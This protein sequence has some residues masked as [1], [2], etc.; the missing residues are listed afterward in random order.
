MAAFRYPWE[1]EPAPVAPS[2]PPDPEDAAG[3]TAGPATR[4]LD[5]PAGRARRDARTGST[6]I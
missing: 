5:H 3:E 1:A 6:I 4:A 2:P